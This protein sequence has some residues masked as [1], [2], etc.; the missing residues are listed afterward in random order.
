VNLDPNRDAQVSTKLAGAAA[1]N[2]T[3]RILTAPA[4]NSMNTFGNPD[5]VKPAAF[6]AARIQ[7]DQIVL[8]LPAKSVV[9]LEIQ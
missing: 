9:V 2:V 6:S 5:A 1:R 8:N 3:G 7:G 4:I